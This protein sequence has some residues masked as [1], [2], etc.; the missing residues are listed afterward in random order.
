MY[1]RNTGWTCRN[2][3]LKPKRGAARSST[4]KKRMGGIIAPRIAER[5][6]LG[7]S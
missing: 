4:M 7:R 3:A 5:K 2:S 1:R 6:D